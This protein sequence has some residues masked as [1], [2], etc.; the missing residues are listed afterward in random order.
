M[1]AQACDWVR[2][3]LELGFHADQA[4]LGHLVRIQ[5]GKTM[6]FTD[7]HAWSDE[8][9]VRALRPQY[10]IEDAFGRTCS[11]ASDCSRTV[12]VV[13]SCSVTD[14][15]PGSGPSTH[16]SSCCR[17]RL[18]A[19][20]RSLSCVSH[21]RRETELAGGCGRAEDPRRTFELARLA[22]VEFRGIVLSSA[23]V[24]PPAVVAVFAKVTP[25]D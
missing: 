24:R 21:G 1:C 20:I 19:G 17:L 15:N 25:F 8:E 10:H 23:A 4:A 18:S 7:N 2:R 3:S 5:F 13:F 16:G 12:W 14:S 6:L 22:G 11:S 9:I